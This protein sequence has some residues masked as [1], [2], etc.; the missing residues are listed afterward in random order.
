MSTPLFFRAYHYAVDCADRHTAWCTTEQK[1]YLTYIQ[2]FVQG[3]V[4][5]TCPFVQALRK[6]YTRISSSNSVCDVRKAKE[7]TT[8]LGDYRKGATKDTCR[9]MYNM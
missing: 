3:V 9:Y 7:C 2:D 5:D 1:Q 8:V 4:G 6:C